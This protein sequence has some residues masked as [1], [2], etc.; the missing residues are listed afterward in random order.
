MGT[1]EIDKLLGAA[2]S[3]DNILNTLSADTI[4]DQLSLNDDAIGSNI[5]EIDKQIQ[6]YDLNGLN[7]I[8][9]L[10]IENSLTEIKDLINDSRDIIKHVKESLITTD[11]ID[12]EAIQAYAK[13][14]ETAHVTL[15]EYIDLYKQRMA[16]YDKIRLATF[17]QSQKI[18]LIKLKHKLDM[19]KNEAKEFNGAITADS[20]A[21]SQEDIIKMLNEQ[22]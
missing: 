12:S 1:K 21:Y 7:G 5:S 11:L 4:S 18:E 13:L 9:T 20:V 6:A 16:F 3:L 10:K 15:A 8:D 19:E 2:E 22:E 17:Y 14:V